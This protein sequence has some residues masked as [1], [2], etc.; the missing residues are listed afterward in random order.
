[1]RH[2]AMPWRKSEQC[3]RNARYCG[4]L[5]TAAATD[6][7]RRILLAMQRSWLALADNEEWLERRRRMTPPAQRRLPIVAG[8]RGHRNALSA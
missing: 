6:A 5:A 1:M 2:L 7:D 4:L 3:R 8:P